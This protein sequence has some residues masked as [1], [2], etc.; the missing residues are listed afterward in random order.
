MKELTQMIKEIDLY[1][2]G[3]LEKAI[4][5]NN[6]WSYYYYLQL[7]KDAWLVHSLDRMFSQKRSVSILKRKRDKVKP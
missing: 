5:G 2:Y 7:L 1:G 4:F 3:G 6:D